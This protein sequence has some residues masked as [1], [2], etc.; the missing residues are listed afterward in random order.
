MFQLNQRV[1]LINNQNQKGRVIDVLQN[2]LYEIEWDNQNIE[3]VELNDLQEITSEPT[4]WDK[5]IN[6]EFDDFGNFT[7]AS[8]IYKIKNTSANTISTLKAS[9]TLFKPYQFIPLL[10]LIK[11]E[12]KRVIVADEVGLG[13]TISAGHIALELAAR[14]ELKS[15]LVICLNSIQEKW[16]D[17]LL[18]KFNIRLKK[19]QTVKEFKK[20]IEDSKNHRD[21]IFGIINFD[22][23][24]QKSDEEF[25]KENAII[26]D[27][28]I[29]DEAHTLRNETNA[30]KSIKPFTDKA[31]S[32]VLLTATPIMTSLENLYNLIK[33]ID[34]EN[35]PNYQVFQN[36]I[37]LNVPFVQ[38]YKKLNSGV[39]PKE[40]A[41]FL[42]N[43]R[44]QSVF[45]YGESTINSES[46]LQ[47]I[48]KN[49]QLFKNLIEELNS[50]EPLSH[51]RKVQI[52]EMLISLNSLN[53]FYTRTRKREVVTQDTSVVRN[54]VVLEIQMNDV[55][56]AIYENKIC[57]KKSDIGSV[58]IKRKFS[59]SLFADN[60]SEEDYHKGN[61][62][63]GHFADTKFEA[64]VGIIKEQ[65]THQLIIF[66]FFRK[67][68]LYLNNRLKGQNY[69]VG[70]ILGGMDLDARNAII[71][72][73]REGRFQILLSSEV[74]STGLDMQFCS[75]MV[76]YDLPW[77]PMVIEQRIGR[78]DRIGQKSEII[79]IFN[80]IYKDTIEE[81][82]YKKLYERIGLFENSL[83]DLDEILG[84]K[85]F[86]IESEIESLYKTDLTKEERDIKL[87]ELASAFEKNKLLTQTIEEGLKDSFSNDLYF[88][89]EIRSIEKNKNYITE[90]DLIE[91][92]NRIVVNKLTFLT[93]NRSE[94]DPKIFEIKQPNSHYINDFV[95]EYMDKN[96]VELNQ[97]YRQFRA[98]NYSNVVKCTFNQEFAFQHKKVEYFSAYHPFINAISNYFNQ[99]NQNRNRVFRFGVNWNKLDE[100][101]KVE[102]SVG[103]YFM[104]NFNFELIKSMGGKS[105]SLIFMKSLVMDLNGEEISILDEESSDNFY[106]ICQQHLNQ[107]PEEGILEFNGELVDE[108]KNSYSPKLFELKK[109][110]ERTEKIKFESEISRRSEMEIQDLEKQ[111]ERRLEY[112]KE[113]KG[114]EAILQFEINEL[115][116]RKEK[117]IQNKKESNI[118]VHSK[119]ISLNYVFVYE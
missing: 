55:E 5:L 68:L 58:Q 100:N 35:F 50:N 38:A 42:K 66:S 65:Q 3:I 8:I 39:E 81:Q 87:D 96:D 99:T 29:I 102:L 63:T 9:K 97:I 91:L 94:S 25:F 14:N 10:K 64:L 53:N 95:D 36:A 17:E 75:R 115:I 4:P 71:D 1:C 92:L 103:Y 46:D 24:R 83:G 110:F 57:N 47:E 20:A 37:N 33:L 54:P 84:Q 117:V 114:I 106:S 41:E 80:F 105:K 93:F 23:F 48:L 78:I 72:E 69:S 118:S 107:I 62:N 51:K 61:C 79:N 112:I 67:T 70:L 109:E 88:E 104:V 59:S 34:P 19:F 116:Q 26:F 2:N 56:S 45:K 82:I 108:L 44:V 43:A 30:R 31:S 111:I 85:Q 98:K 52:K 12:K 7:I 86:Y 49:D 6:N 16:E 90:K 119:L 32:L 21:P 15:L 11:S 28:I 22:K 60:F 74:G 40:I 13:K 101:Q 27:L 113:E 18:N 77:N 73:F 89:N 76:N